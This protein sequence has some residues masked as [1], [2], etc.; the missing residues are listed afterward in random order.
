MQE[1]GTGEV[2][3][4]VGLRSLGKPRAEVL[5]KL[6]GSYLTGVSHHI[7]ILGER[8]VMGLEN[9]CTRD[10]IVGVSVVGTRHEIG[11]SQEENRCGGKTDEK[12]PSV[13]RRVSTPSGSPSYHT[14]AYL[15][16]RNTPMTAP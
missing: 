5:L 10:P 15:Y 3:D 9:T 1:R 14:D 6:G 11:R 8:L 4:G 16:F 7:M 13:R 12:K 2:V